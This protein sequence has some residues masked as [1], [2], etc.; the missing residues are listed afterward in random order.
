MICFTL[1]EKD[2]NKQ[3]QAL[4]LQLMGETG[5]ELRETGGDW[6]R[7]G[8]TRTGGTGTGERPGETGGDYH[9]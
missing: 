7:P 5:G 4:G 2:V 8:E 3:A 1:F 6:G 9:A